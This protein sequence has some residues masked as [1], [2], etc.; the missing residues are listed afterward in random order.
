[1]ILFFV[2][3]GASL[4][5]T[6]LGNAGSWL[7]AYVV[8]RVIG[9]IAGAWLAGG[10]ARVEPAARRW[11]GLALLPQAGVALGMALVASERLPEAGAQILPVVVAA[12]VIFE[13]L[14]PLATRH[15]LERTAPG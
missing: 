4:E 1:M 5:V 7:A 13:L 3:A 12:T 14:G 15:A 6:A 11:M 8:L 2:L 10:I 9:R